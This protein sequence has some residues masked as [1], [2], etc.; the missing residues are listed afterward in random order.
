MFL[1]RTSNCTAFPVF[2][3]HIFKVT[4][5]IQTQG[6]GLSNLLYPL[7]TIQHI[8]VENNFI[9]SLQKQH[10]SCVIKEITGVLR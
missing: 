5:A 10:Y 6:D 8:I 1:G 7:G 9:W 2:S 4:E 3:N